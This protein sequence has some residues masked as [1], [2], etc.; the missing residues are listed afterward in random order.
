[1]ETRGKK[2]GMRNC[3][4]ADQ[5]G[6]NNWTVKNRSNNNNNNNNNNNKEQE[7]IE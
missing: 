6:G 5:E 7:Q 4:R 2:N 1:L 3:G